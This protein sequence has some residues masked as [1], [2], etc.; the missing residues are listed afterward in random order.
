MKI[1]THNRYKRNIRLTKKWLEY[2][3]RM[4]HWQISKFLFEHNS[5]SETDPGR[6]QRN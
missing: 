2:T 6:P 1:I 5:R 4:E 3:E